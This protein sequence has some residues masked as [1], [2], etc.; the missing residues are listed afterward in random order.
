MLQQD[1]PD[2]FVIATGKTTKIRD[3]VLSAFS[4][5]GI[6][7][8]FTGNGVKET[9]I[10]KGIAQSPYYKLITKNN[11]DYIYM[12]CQLLNPSIFNKK[13]KDDV[14]SMNEIWNTLIQKNSLNGYV[15]NS[16]F[17]H[18]TNLEI[19]NQLNQS[20]TIGL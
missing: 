14:F 9:G 2:D 15:S 19:Y 1:E 11:K 16:I 13:N 6:S 20:K 5:V 18:A 8:D 12:G 3:F 17:L 7:I 4:K 10:V